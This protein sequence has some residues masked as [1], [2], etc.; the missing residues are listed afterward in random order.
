MVQIGYDL[1][2]SVVFLLQGKY[3]EAVAILSLTGHHDKHQR[4]AENEV[5]QGVVVVCH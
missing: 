3:L 5:D 2:A 1:V 4:L